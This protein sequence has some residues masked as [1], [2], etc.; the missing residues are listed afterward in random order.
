M[1]S[2]A[3]LLGVMQE[4]L[5]ETR[6]LRLALEEPDR[7][8]TDGELCRLLKISDRSLRRYLEDTSAV[9]VPGGPLLLGG[10]R[11]ARRWDPRTAPAFVAEARRLYLQRI[12]KACEPAPKPAPA[13]RRPRSITPSKGRPAPHPSPDKPSAMAREAAARAARQRQED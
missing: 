10:E 1:S 12:G 11:G 9:T 8:L 3:A 4:I 6:A 7:F 2:E 13:P 5:Q